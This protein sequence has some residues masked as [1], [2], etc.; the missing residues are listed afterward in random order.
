MASLD[1]FCVKSENG[2]SAEA[3]AVGVRDR[4]FYYV[5]LQYFLNRLNHTKSSIFCSL[6]ELLT[7]RSS[8]RIL[9][10]IKSLSLAGVKCSVAAVKKLLYHIFLVLIRS[11][12]FQTNPKYL[13]LSYKI[14]VDLLDY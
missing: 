4:Q 14:G 3:D 5:T 13:D 7:S 9:S 11:F 8:S 10:Y 1:S 2:V 6:D 12:C